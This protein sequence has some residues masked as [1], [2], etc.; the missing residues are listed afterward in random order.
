M[1][2]EEQKR[3]FGWLAEGKQM[4]IKTAG[5]EWRSARLLEVL[6]AV[7]DDDNFYELRVRPSMMQIGKQLVEAPVLEPEDGQMV[8][9]WSDHLGY[10]SKIIFRDGLAQL[11]RSGQCF[12]AKEACEAAHAA[13]QAYVLEQCGGESC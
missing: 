1:K 2:P 13:I 5:T 11:S 3:I 9:V 6:D 7:L 4:Q 10:A 8:W 12:E